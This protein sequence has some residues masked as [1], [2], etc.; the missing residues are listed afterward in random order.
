MSTLGPRGNTAFTGSHGRQ[1]ARRRLERSAFHLVKWYE[2]SALINP[3]TAFQGPTAPSRLSPLGG[4]Q[5][6]L[7]RALLIG[8]VKLGSPIPFCNEET[9]SDGWAL[10]SLAPCRGE[11]GLLLGSAGLGLAQ[12]CSG[13]FHAQP[14][15]QEQ[16]PLL[17][18]AWLSWSPPKCPVG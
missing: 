1:V 10:G 4:P 9:D 14:Q 11:D 7:C 3:Q 12:S 16:L 13:R 5:A 2:C 8:L 15:R 18:E 6:G 17:N